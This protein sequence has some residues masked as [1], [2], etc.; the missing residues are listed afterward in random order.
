M[1]TCVVHEIAFERG[2]GVTVAEELAKA[3]DADLFI[4]YAPADVVDKI[5]VDVSLLYGDRLASIFHNANLRR[6]FYAKNARS[7]PEIEDYDVVIQSGSLLH[8]YNPPAHQ[9]LVRYYHSAGYPFNLE[10][11]NL[12]QIIYSWIKSSTFNYPDVS[13]A[14]SDLTKEE[15]EEWTDSDINILYPPVDVEKYKNEKSE[16]FITITRLTEGKKVDDL[17][18]E[19]VDIEDDLKVVGTG[20]LEKELKERSPDNVEITGW[21]SDKQKIELLAGAKAFINHSGNE[22][23]GISTVEGMASGIPVLCKEGGFTTIDEDTGIVYED[24]QDGISTYRD[25]EW[26]PQH[27]MSY[28]QEEYGKDRFRETVMDVLK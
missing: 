6:L 19:F 4:G 5:D 1:K 22:S 16:Y 27:I 8:W 24:L 12:Y 18:Q 10:R 14:N 17:I 3:A 13:F 11:R 20:P 7:I 2:G 21:I 25:R 26:D 15:V 9:K 23:F 28:A